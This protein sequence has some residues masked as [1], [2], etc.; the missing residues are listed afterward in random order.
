MSLRLEYVTLPTIPLGRDEV[1]RSVAWPEEFP[2]WRSTWLSAD[3]R[4][5]TFFAN[6]GDCEAEARNAGCAVWLSEVSIAA[7]QD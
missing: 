7:L 4:N 2:L 6:Q 3:P 1:T 5:W